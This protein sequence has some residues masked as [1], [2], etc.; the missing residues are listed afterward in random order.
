MGVAISETGETVAV[1]QV[2]HGFGM[3]GRMELGK[4]APGR[5]RFRIFPR[6]AMGNWTWT[7]WYL[8]EVRQDAV[9]GTRNLLQNPA[10]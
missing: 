4:L 9:T 5:Y 1:Q 10:E 7:P 3:N 8:L 6:D 2:Y